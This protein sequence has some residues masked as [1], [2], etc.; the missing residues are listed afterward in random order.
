L[1]KYG[2]ITNLWEGGYMGD[3]F[4]QELKPRLK[5]G[6]NRNWQVHLLSNVLKQDSMSR[7]KLP[8]ESPF[9]VQQT[10]REYHY[11]RY[12]HGHSM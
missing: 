3:K 8:T 9:E 11:T 12:N 4:S 5:R 2:P 7:I 1:E 10:E 6:V